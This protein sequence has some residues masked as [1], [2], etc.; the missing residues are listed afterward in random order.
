[1]HSYGHRRRWMLA[2]LL[3]GA[4]AAVQAVEFDEK[5]KAPSAV[6]W[7]GSAQVEAATEA[8]RRALAAA[9]RAATAALEMAAQL[10]ERARLLRDLAQE[11]AAGKALV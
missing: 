5:V 10:E 9:P 7:Y 1:M 8:A 2:L 3:A 11:A 4:A 6:E